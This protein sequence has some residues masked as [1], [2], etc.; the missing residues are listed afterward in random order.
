MS[1]KNFNIVCYDE[2]LLKEFLLEYANSIK[3]Y[4][5]IKHLPESE[6]KKEH[7]HVF[8]EFF[9]P[10]NHS[11]IA[12]QLNVNIRLVQTCKD[13]YKLIR[14]FVHKDNLDKIQY[15]IDEIITDMDINVIYNILNDINKYKRDEEF[16]SLQL[17]YL[18]SGLTLN[19]L[20]ALAIS[21]KNLA[22]LRKYWNI[23]KY[24]YEHL[25]IFLTK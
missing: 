9:N 21:N 24:Y 14:Y 22:E 7:Y 13:R 19:N 3:E 11:T 16:L 25:S 6:E 15:E 18:H 2:H 1:A 5:Y 4:A 23:I 20:I 17:D 10:K 12:K 8:I